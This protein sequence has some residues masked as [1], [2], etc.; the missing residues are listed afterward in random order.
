[1]KTMPRTDKILVRF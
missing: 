1:M